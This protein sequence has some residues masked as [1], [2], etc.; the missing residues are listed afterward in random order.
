MW[1]LLNFK[2]IL[3]LI[4]EYIFLLLHMHRLYPVSEY[5]SLLIF[6]DFEVDV[7]QKCDFKIFKIDAI[8]SHEILNRFKR[9]TATVDDIHNVFN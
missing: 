7:D 9:L 6:V 2:Q 5:S 8:S 3:F 4:Q 1:T